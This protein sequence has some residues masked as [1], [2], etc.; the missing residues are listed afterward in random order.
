M[1]HWLNNHPYKMLFVPAAL[2]LLISLLI[3]FSFLDGVHFGSV[4]GTIKNT[5]S[6]HYK[7]SSLSFAKL[8][9]VEGNTIDIICEIRCR[10]GDKIHVQIYRTLIPGKRVYIYKT[11]F[12]YPEGI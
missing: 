12:S 1:L 3:H 4:Q 11:V 8:E 6:E 7:S 9:T 2:L 10:V 5:Y